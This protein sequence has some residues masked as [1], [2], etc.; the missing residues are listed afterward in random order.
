MKQIFDRI[1]NIFISK[2]LYDKEVLDEMEIILK[3]QGYI[4][5]ER[6]LAEKMNRLEDLKIPEG[7]NFKLLKSISTEGR[8]K[9]SKF[10][11]S[12]IGQA[13]R[14]PGVSRSDINILLMKFG[15]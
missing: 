14:I 10:K 6:Q 3:Y 4:V 13:S 8:Q 12:T 11:P 9:L 15:R 1:K 5:R 2:G 7:Y